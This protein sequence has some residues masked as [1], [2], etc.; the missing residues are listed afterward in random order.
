MFL[1]EYFKKD[2]MGLVNYVL[3]YMNSFMV[4]NMELI[5]FINKNYLAGKD[6]DR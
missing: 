1:I 3:T 5:E 2:K 4:K 6:K